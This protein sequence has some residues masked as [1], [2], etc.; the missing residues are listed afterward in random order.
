MDVA[1]NKSNGH[2]ANG[3]RADIGELIYIDQ[4]KKETILPPEFFLSEILQGTESDVA[5]GEMARAQIYD[6][7]GTLAWNPKDSLR[8][9]EL[10]IGMEITVFERDNR[11]DKEISI[12]YEGGTVVSEPYFAADDLWW[13]DVEREDYAGNSFR[14]P[15]CLAIWGVTMDDNREWNPYFYV[16]PASFD[17]EQDSL[18][19]NG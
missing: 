2:A 10:S 15:R 4:F 11:N 8:I 19:L 18:N 3:V 6:S 17:P 12:P 13:V 16:V 14:R 5:R 1:D 9:D 7:D